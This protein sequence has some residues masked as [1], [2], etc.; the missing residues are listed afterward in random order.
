[1]CYNI[2]DKD[3]PEKSRL[4]GGER[5]HFPKAKIRKAAVPKPRCVPS[6]DAGLPN[7]WGRAGFSV[8]GLPEI[9]TEVRNIALVFPER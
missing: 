3:F 4:L 8:P 7:H 9:T 2:K 6:H 1:M 5:A